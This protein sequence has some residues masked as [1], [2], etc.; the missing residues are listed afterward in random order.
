MYGVREQWN[1]RRAGPGQFLEALWFG[2]NAA[3]QLIEIVFV[4]QKETAH[5]DRRRA[6]SHK[7]K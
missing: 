6:V 4:G 5:L 3:W 2:S 1:L 7:E